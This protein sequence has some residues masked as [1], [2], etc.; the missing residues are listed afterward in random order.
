MHPLIH[1]IQD[2]KFI[3]IPL[4]QHFLRKVPRAIFC[5]RQKFLFRLKIQPESIQSI[6]KAWGFCRYRAYP[7]PSWGYA[8]PILQQLAHPLLGL[9]VAIFHCMLSLTWRIL[10]AKNWACPARCKDIKRMICLDWTNHMAWKQKNVKT[11]QENNGTSQGSQWHCERGNQHKWQ[12][13]TGHQGVIF[14]WLL[15][16]LRC[17]DFVALRISHMHVC[18]SGGFTGPYFK[19]LLMMAWGGV[20]WGGV[21]GCNNVHVCCLTC[22]ATLMLRSCLG[23][24]GWGMLAFMWSW[25]RCGCCVEHAVH[26]TL[27]VW[28]GG[29]GGVRHVSKHSCEVEHAVDVTLNTLC[30]LRDPQQDKVWPEAWLL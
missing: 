17:F 6:I 22:D 1:A 11:F 18:A 29:C 28:G 7:V 12:Y 23:G 30:M 14:F 8:G 20:G 26:V 24:V 25:A 2:E 4:S 3:S 9:R 16:M 10:L 19:V 15:S 5:L 21:G 27:P 13:M